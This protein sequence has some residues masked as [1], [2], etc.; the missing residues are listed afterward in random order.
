MR[1]ERR[2]G[3]AMFSVGSEHPEKR[4]RIA[5]IESKLDKLVCRG[6]N[7]LSPYAGPGSTLTSRPSRGGDDAT[8]SYQA[9]KAESC[10]APAVQ[11]DRGEPSKPSPR[12]LAEEP[13][14]RARS[15]SGMPVPLC[16]YVEKFREDRRKPEP[17][18]VVVSSRGP[19]DFSPT[20]SKPGTP[21]P[22]S[23]QVEKPGKQ[24]AERR[25]VQNPYVRPTASPKQKDA[26][27]SQKPA[28]RLPPWRLHDADSVDKRATAREAVRH[29]A[30]EARRPSAGD[31]K[32]DTPSVRK[33][34]LPR[35]S[36]A[37]LAPQGSSSQEED[38]EA[39]IQATRAGLAE[40]P[41]RWT[42]R[43]LLDSFPPCRVEQET[44]IDVSDEASTDE[45]QEDADHDKCEDDPP[46]PPSDADVTWDTGAE[47]ST[48]ADTHDEPGT[49]SAALQ[50]CTSQAE[51]VP[52]LA[53]C[54]WNP[55]DADGELDMKF[56]SAGGFTRISCCWTPSSGL[57][58]ARGHPGI[59]SGSGVFEVEIVAD[60]DMLRIGWS[61]ENASRTMGEEPGSFAVSCSGQVWSESCFPVPYGR[62][63]HV[64]DIVGCLL[65][66]D[67]HYAVFTINGESMGRAYTIPVS[68]DCVPLYPT[69][70]GQDGFVVHVYLGDVTRDSLGLNFGYDEF[71]PVGTAVEGVCAEP[72]YLFGEQ[73]VEEDE[74]ENMAQEEPEVEVMEGEDLIEAQEHE[75]FQE[76]VTPCTEVP[77]I[78]RV[79]C[80]T[81]K[82]NVSLRSPRPFFEGATPTVNEL[83][84]RVERSKRFDTKGRVAVPETSRFDE[85]VQ[86]AA[87]TQERALLGTC[88][89]LE[90][91]FLRLTTLPRASDVRPLPVLRKALSLA[92]SRWWMQE[93]DWAHTGEMLRSI[94]QDLTVQMIRNEFTVEVYE[95]STRSALEAGDL[96]Q[97]DQCSTQLDDLH[98]DATIDPSDN[99]TEFLAY[100]LLYLMLQGDSLALTGFLSQRQAEIQ[101]GL[102]AGHHQLQ[103]AW[104][105]RTAM[106]DASPLRAL[107]C[108]AFVVPS[109][110]GGTSALKRLVD[111]LLEGTKL[112]CAA[113]I[114]K[115]HYQPTRRLLARILG[116]AVQTSDGVGS[117]PLAGLPVVLK[118]EDVVDVAP[119]LAEIDRQ[120]SKAVGGKTSTEHV[121]GFVR[122]S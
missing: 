87:S 67:E 5:A 122:S 16:P 27:P 18:P 82:G 42:V 80:L 94:R 52:P 23:Q 28:E 83:R 1:A 64:G 63:M 8:S 9:R 78:V 14:E 6:R 69:V 113:A 119:T 29:A 110:E 48:T 20:W 13:R 86:K 2:H 99:A 53:E 54:G 81:L 39:T 118:S 104:G 61:Q 3:L 45:K 50:E 102:D 15:L 47:A 98:A 32:V 114:C 96:R 68:L 41:R 120:L 57:A 44:A 70:C 91:P 89:D 51:D 111:L 62:L 101:S 25:S 103:L 105:L 65:H 88:T 75:P 12:R 46:V 92:Q 37:S 115:G 79:P 21:V 7:D 59:I 11:G 85:V 22:T 56:D 40:K 30:R 72:A 77:E 55:E 33:R 117:D 10:R 109:Q 71:F 34:L 100:R 76:D 43:G 108:I 84:A 24:A 35:G 93:R 38:S 31:S 60:S 17:P 95:F 73:E 97:F 4:A 49:A 90:K 121:K 116:G 19:D 26:L 66:R 112:R 107:R 58:G 106:G 74:V 36:A